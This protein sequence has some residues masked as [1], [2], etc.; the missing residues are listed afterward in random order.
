MYVAPVSASIMATRRGPDESG[1]D[2]LESSD[3]P[4]DDCSAAVAG[5]RT[6]TAGP[7]GPGPRRR[8]SRDPARPPTADP[9]CRRDVARVA[10]GVS[11]GAAGVAGVGG[12]REG[13]R[14]RWAPADVPRG[15]GPPGGHPLGPGPTPPVRHDSVSTVAFKFQANHLFHRNNLTR[16]QKF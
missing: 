6:R 10:W 9:K 8:P 4:D 3:G 16:F 1:D 2:R 7:G 11:A 12:G 13:D 15:R 14:F 5:A